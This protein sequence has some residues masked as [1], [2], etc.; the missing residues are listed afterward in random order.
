MQA[1]NK[2]LFI[3]PSARVTGPRGVQVQATSLCCTLYHA[4]LDALGLCFIELTQNPSGWQTKLLRGPW[5]CSAI[6]QCLGSWSQQNLPAP[7]KS[8]Q[9]DAVS[10]GLGG[11][12]A[13]AG[14][15]LPSD[16]SGG[17]RHRA[18]PCCWKSLFP[19]WNPTWEWSPFVCRGWAQAH[20]LQC[21]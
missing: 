16:L 3:P 15:A 13:G 19:C 4:V 20:P 12:E 18:D 14:L 1:Q 7:I 9:A 2:V 6:R 17:I 8:E 11:K 21:P 5:C 10:V